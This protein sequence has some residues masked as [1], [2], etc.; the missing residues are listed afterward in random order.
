MKNILKMVRFDL[1]TVEKLTAPYV[2]AFCVLSTAAAVVGIPL[3]AMLPLAAICMVAP[4]EMTVDNESRRIYSVLP[5]G[6]DSVLQARFYEYA[7]L[8]MS[9][10]LLGIICMVISKCSKL[11]TLLPE[12]FENV[13]DWIGSIF[14]PHKNIFGL[15]FPE[16]L[17]LFTVIS[18][19]VLI[20]ISYAKAVQEI[21]GLI[22][23]AV[24]LIAFVTLCFVLIFINVGKVL[25]DKGI[26]LKAFVPESGFVKVAIAVILNI[27]AVLVCIYCCRLTVKK[28]EGRESL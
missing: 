2:I 27:V 4:T 6:R 19:L 16:L 28:T 13:S 20:I 14:D 25:D 7:V 24:Q 9:G 23:A 1:I 21:Q 18:A 11:Y 10:E 12:N 3:G 8:I 26:P 17:F 22:M 5:I 15:S